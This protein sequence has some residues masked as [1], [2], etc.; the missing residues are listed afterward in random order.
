MDDRTQILPFTQKPK[1][2]P[3][4]ADDRITSKNYNQKALVFCQGLGLSEF[5]TIKPVTPEWTA[6]ERYFDTHL[7]WRPAIF[8][9]VLAGR[10]A[11]MTVPTQWPEW[12]DSSFAGSDV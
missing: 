6:W 4:L 3:T 11:V 10:K 9:A 1:P 8:N 2:T 7:R 5:P 12:F